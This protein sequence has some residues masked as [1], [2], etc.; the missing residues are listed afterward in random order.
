MPSIQFSSFTKPDDPRELLRRVAE[1]SG[2]ER[3]S[4]VVR[5]SRRQWRYVQA[6]Q[7]L[8]SLR[9]RRSKV[10]LISGAEHARLAGES[11]VAEDG[12][13]SELPRLYADGS[14]LQ[15]LLG[16]C[17]WVRRFLDEF[18]E[19]APTPERGDFF[20]NGSGHIQIGWHDVLIHD[21]NWDLQPAGR[22]FL[23]F[24][25][26]GSGS[27]QNQYVIR[28]FI[29]SMESTKDLQARLEQIA[30]DVTVFVDF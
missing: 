24:M 23:S 4:S 5:V 9:L 30:S 22:A 26:S 11:T 28:D 20:F 7:R 12:P 25:I 1:V 17:P 6:V 27:P 2:S 18:K 21:A 8:V 19:R 14:S 10:A 29:L 16:K 15:I 3:Y 13:V